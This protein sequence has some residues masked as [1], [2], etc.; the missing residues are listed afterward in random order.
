VVVKPL[1]N[2]A[3]V[4]YADWVRSNREYVAKKS[5]G[6]I[7]YIH[8]TDMQA[9]GMTEFDTWYYPQLD[10][11]GMVIDVR[12]NHGGF[13]SE[14]ILERLRRK[15]DAWNLARSGNQTTYP[16]RTLNGP[17][18]VV[19]NQFAGSD[20]DIFPAAVQL[21]K[22]AP[23]IGMRSWGGVIGI[24]GIRP[25]VDLGLITEP[26]GSW[27]D[28][29]SGWTIENHGVD[30]DIVVEN[31][32]TEVAQ[33]KDPQL[34]RAI[35]EVMK[36]VQQQPASQPKLNAIRNRRRGAFQGE[37]TSGSTSTSSRPSGGN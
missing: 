26:E 12:W 29:K 6:K 31:S 22:L 16:Y 17:F 5:G 35:A 7:G 27:N 11:Q 15:V 21:E 36:L 20:G 9:A 19:T 33:G 37:M 28:P 2:D 18:V 13:V 8:L 24:N 23:V 25:L 14:I 3:D 30:P 10:K 4:R 1:G 32:P 34:D